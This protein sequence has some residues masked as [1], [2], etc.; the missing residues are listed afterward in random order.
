MEN[1]KI[2]CLECLWFNVIWAVKNKWHKTVYC[3]KAK[4]RVKPS[5]KAC[6]NKKIK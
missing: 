2:T 1:E 4:R 5:S 3:P 6:K